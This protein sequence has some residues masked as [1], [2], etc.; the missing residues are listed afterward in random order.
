VLIVNL[1]DMSS[2]KCR[3][4]TAGLLGLS[5]SL[6]IAV[7][8]LTAA[9]VKYDE[10]FRESDSRDGGRFPSDGG[11]V[12]DYRIPPDTLPLH[13]ELYL[14]PF[15]ETGVFQGKVFIHVDVREKRDYLVV[16]VKNLII[17]KSALYRGE[18]TLHFQFLPR[19]EQLWAHNC[20]LTPRKLADGVACW[21]SALTPPREDARSI[22]NPGNP[23]PTQGIG[24]SP[25]FGDLARRF[26]LILNMA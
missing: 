19:A 26:C 2:L 23:F 18:Q 12:D 11:W 13:Y 1:H 9:I 20:V 7:V 22:P 25:L 21:S 3:K 14:N 15:M 6:A 5:A 4:S 10:L 8:A 16:H 17:G 24:A